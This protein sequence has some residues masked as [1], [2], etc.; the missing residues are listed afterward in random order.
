MFSLS[1]VHIQKAYEYTGVGLK[2]ISL[3]RRHFTKTSI[4]D[5]SGSRTDY[6]FFVQRL[7]HTETASLA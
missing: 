2:N 5:L 3:W 4:I 6:F 7:I 1:I